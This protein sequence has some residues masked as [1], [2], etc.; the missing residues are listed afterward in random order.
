M[1]V[2]VSPR[3]GGVTPSSVVVLSGPGGSGGNICWSVC[4]ALSWYGGTVF[5]DVGSISDVS[6]A[7]VGTSS[8]SSVSLE[9]TVYPQVV[10][11]DL[12]GRSSK[13]FCHCV[14]FLWHWLRTCLDSG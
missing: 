4:R 3:H 11:L 5:G 9:R 13:Y 12:V 14:L 10:S 1:E 7:N 6:C 8:C 2:E